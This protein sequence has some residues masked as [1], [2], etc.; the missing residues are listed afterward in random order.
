M[1]ARLIALSFSVMLL[2]ACGG[3]FG[4]PAS[5]AVPPASE[6]KAAAPQKVYWTL[7][8]GPAYPQVQIA[9]VPLKV[10]SKANSID[11]SSQNDLL[12]SSG[13]AIDSAGRL[14]ILSFGQ[15]NG[16][17]TS[18]LVFKLPLDANSVPLYTFV[19]TGTSGADA[20]AFDPSGDVWV[21]S[22]GTHEVFEYK[23]PFT[24]SKTLNPAV[25]L[26]GGSDNPFGI[27][28]DKSA[29]VYISINNSTGTDSIAVA[30][31]PYKH[32][33]YFLNGL[34]APGGLMFDKSG[35]L[36]A[37]SNG[38]APALVRYNS[39]NLKNGATPNIVDP[40]GLPAS[41]YEAAFAFT[42]KGDLYAANCGNSGTAGLDVWPLSAKKF[43]SKLPPSVQYTN[44][45]LQSVGCA[46][47]IAI[48]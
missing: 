47:G 37:S 18:A 8:A 45:D 39:N 1:N 9:N 33:P 38:S 48:K 2:S 15:S 24:K 34:T 11:S 16:A 14:W 23:G 42:A 25:T 29:K 32:E 13:M 17:P 44:A 19:L 36:Y 27:A 3:R 20:L 22:P 6:A 10:K 41:S 46:W 26:N 30:T 40:T 21:T 31:P 12:Y 7:F 5:T 35:N 4:P 28:V 43:T